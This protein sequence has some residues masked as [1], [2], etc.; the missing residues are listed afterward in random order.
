[1]KKPGPWV[2]LCNHCESLIADLEKESKAG[3]V[4]Q[5]TGLLRVLQVLSKELRTLPGMQKCPGQVV[6][7]W[8]YPNLNGRKL[9]SGRG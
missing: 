2:L 3:K 1:M 9:T 8:S 6:C 7:S 4:V 5:L